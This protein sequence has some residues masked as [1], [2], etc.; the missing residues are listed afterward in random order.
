MEL[1][2]YE[3]ADKDGQHTLYNAKQI[4]NIDDVITF[5]ADITGNI[6]TLEKTIEDD[7]GKKIK[8]IKK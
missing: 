2:N 5:E 4:E 3:I 1:G 7:T 6:K 8:L